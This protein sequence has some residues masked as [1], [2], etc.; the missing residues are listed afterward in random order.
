VYINTHASKVLAGRKKMT[1]NQKISL[2]IISKIQGG[3]T[4]E[5]AVDAVL[6]AGSFKKI[7]EDVWTALRA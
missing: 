4:V 1:T 2:A 6:G 7:A 3:M 5:Q